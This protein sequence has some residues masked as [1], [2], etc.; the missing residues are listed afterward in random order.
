[1][2]STRQKRIR[3]EIGQ[4]TVEFGRSLPCEHA[5]GYSSWVEDWLFPKIVTEK[6]DI[7]SIS[8]AML[9]LT[10]R[11]RSLRS[12]VTKRCRNHSGDRGHV[13][14]FHIWDQ[15]HERLEALESTVEKPRLFE[16]NSPSRK[17]EIVYI[18]RLYGLDVE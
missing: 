10:R 8:H 14:I 6:P 18:D 4:I 1:M 9:L 15:T 16:E 7:V 3:E 5:K 11:Y 12:S 13:C 17:E 2:T